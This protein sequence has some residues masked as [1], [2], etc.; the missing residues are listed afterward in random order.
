MLLTILVI[1]SLERWPFWISRDCAKVLGNSWGLN[2]LIF[3]L[4]PFGAVCQ[5]WCFCPLREYNFNKEPDYMC[6]DPYDR[7]VAYT[8]V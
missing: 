5:I 4:C 3:L 6:P 8:R 1:A 7:L 2:R